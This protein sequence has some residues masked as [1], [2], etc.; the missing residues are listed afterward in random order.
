M[1]GFLSSM[2]D[3]PVIRPDTRNTQVRGPDASRHA[4]K[5]PL[6]ESFRVVTSITMPPRPPTDSA[7]PPSAPG[8]AGQPDFGQSA[9]VVGEDGAGGVGF[10]VVAAAAT[11]T[12]VVAG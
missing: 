11:G 3:R 7:P 8:N 12:F 9:E 6:P 10:E 2:R 4:R 1:Y 5:L